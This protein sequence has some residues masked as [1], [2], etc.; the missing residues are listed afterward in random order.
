MATLIKDLD[1]QIIWKN[2]S[3]SAPILRFRQRELRTRQA[4]W[5]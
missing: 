2:F 1:P 5:Q 4:K 3:F